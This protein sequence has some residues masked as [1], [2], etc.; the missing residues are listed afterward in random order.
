[1]SACLPFVTSSHFFTSTPLT[2]CCVMS[3]FPLMCCCA[4]VELYESYVLK[5]ALGTLR[6]CKPVLFIELDCE[7]H[8][9]VILPQLMKIGYEVA[10]MPYATVRP[11]NP[12]VDK[13]FS[14]NKYTDDQLLTIVFGAAYVMAVRREH[15]EVVFANPD[16]NFVRISLEKGVLARDYGIERCMPRNGV[17]ASLCRMLVQLPNFN[18]S[19][20][21]CSFHDIVAAGFWED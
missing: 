17:P 12:W 15:S 18:N 3:S 19:C 13:L 8:A 1:M 10:Y 21:L 2:H 14:Y 6:R 7:L 4:D 9:S 11:N 20:N 5:G 16:V